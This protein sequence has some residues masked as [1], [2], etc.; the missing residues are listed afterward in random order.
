MLYLK[1]ADLIF[2]VDYSEY[3]EDIFNNPYLSKQF[4]KYVCNSQVPDYSIKF[5]CRKDY[6]GIGK[7]DISDDWKTAEFINYVVNDIES[8]RFFID[9][10][11][12][13]S[14]YMQGA[15]LRCNSFLV[16]SV[17]L[18]YQGKGLIFPAAA[19]VGKTTHTT[20]WA[21]NFGAEIL[22]GDSPIIKIVDGKPFIYG[23][24][25][26]GSSEITVNKVVPLDAIVILSRGTE[27][28]IH[29]LNKFEAV[30]YLFNHI[31][32][33]AWDADS[34]NICLDYCETLINTLNIYRLE[35]LPNSDSAEVARRGIIELNEH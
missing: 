25:W 16:H 21:E 30:G 9:M 35:C 10:L 15:I 24:P 18:Q 23:S 17:A 29:K 27:N 33:P 6:N 31:K 22:N 1:I 20:F 11:A 3:K 26:C 7:I 4:L 13:L 34:A 12:G 28:K 14:H 32:R 5:T 19:G 2:A 8:Y